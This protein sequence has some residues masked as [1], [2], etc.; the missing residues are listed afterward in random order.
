[1]SRDF[2]QEYKD[3]MTEQT[4]DLW[5]R[6]ETGISE[7]DVAVKKRQ[8]AAL[9][10]RKKTLRRYASYGITAAAA[11]LI[12]VSATLYMG[13]MGAKSADMA[14]EN[15]A[16][17]GEMVAQD[18]AVQDV[19]SAEA[20]DEGGSEMQM[21][22]DAGVGYEDAK[23][24]T[25]QE[26]ASQ[27]AVPEETEK[28]QQG[29]NATTELETSRV[30]KLE[31]VILGEAEN[32]DASGRLLQAKI[33]GQEQEMTLL[34]TEEITLEP[35]NGKTYRVGVVPGKSEDAYDYKVLFFE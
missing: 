9:V 30:L 5:N 27:E 24:E 10:K 25:A 2:N 14:A 3:Y 11:L 6:I 34:L 28:L 21:D 26:T 16:M 33:N 4:P 17:A 1:M 31:V 15:K 32:T 13:N 7:K 19:S 29:E 12:C 22:A 35:E 18:M 20:Q 23:V 8:T